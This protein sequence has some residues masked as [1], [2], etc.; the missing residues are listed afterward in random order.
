MFKASG[1]SAATARKQF[2]FQNMKERSEHVQICIEKAQEIREAIDK[3]KD[4]AL[5]VAMSFSSLS[6][7]ESDTDVESELEGSQHS[8]PFSSTR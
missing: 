2:G 4:R 1:V 3:V 7:A 8:L 6:S 5:L